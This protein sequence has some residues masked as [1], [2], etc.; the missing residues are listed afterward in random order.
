MRASGQRRGHLP[1]RGARG[2]TPSSSAAASA[3]SR[4]RCGSGARGLPRHGARAARRARRPRLRATGRTASPSTPGRRSSPRRSCSRSCGSCAAGGCADDVELRPVDAVL[5]HPLRR[6]RD[7]STTAATP[8]AMRARGRAA[9]ARRRRRLRALHARERGDLPRRLRA[10][11]PR[12]VRL[13]GPTWRASLPDLVRLRELPHASTAWS[14]RYVRDPRL[15]VVLSF[16]PLLVGGNP[17][18][19]D[20]DLQPDRATSSGAGACTSRWAAPG[21]SCRA[22]SS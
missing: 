18:R 1:L 22:W 20:V 8:T 6:R 11:R 3:G 5:P 4:R 13:A 10:A 2:R 12:A 16:H 14:P 7:A 17:F 15:R 9:R 21:A 19:D